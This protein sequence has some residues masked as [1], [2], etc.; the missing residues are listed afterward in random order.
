MAFPVQ[1]AQQG[2]LGAVVH[3]LAIDVQDERRH[4]M[5]TVGTFGG[6]RFGFTVGPYDPSR[7]LIVD[8]PSERIN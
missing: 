8:P 7:T 2:D 4:R 6:T 3:H 1:V 5:L